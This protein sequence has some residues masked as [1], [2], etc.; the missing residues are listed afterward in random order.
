MPS[1]G[2]KNF[3]SMS[4]DKEFSGGLGFMVNGLQHKGWVKIQLRWMDD[5]TITF[6][7]KKREV[8]KV[9][10]GIFCDQLVEML[11]YVEGR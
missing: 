10:K 8:V 2:A 6:V 4:E 1:V 11:D 7:N 9:L 5:Y 3:H